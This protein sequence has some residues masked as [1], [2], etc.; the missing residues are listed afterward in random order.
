[1]CLDSHGVRKLLDASLL[2]A[3]CGEE[4]G[5]GNSGIILAS[6]V[7]WYI[8]CRGSL[9]V[10]RKIEA[11]LPKLL[12]LVLPGQSNSLLL[13]RSRFCQKICPNCRGLTYHVPL[14][15]FDGA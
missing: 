11:L 8:A 12:D 4:F 2:V 1:M 7:L 6:N 10:E 9:D 5:S 15:M 14:M 3:A 13:L